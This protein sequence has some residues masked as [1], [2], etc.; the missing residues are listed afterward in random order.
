MNPHALVAV[1]YAAGILGIVALDMIYRGLQPGRESISFFEMP[2]LIED[3]DMHRLADDG[4][5]IINKQLIQN[6]ENNDPERERWN[7]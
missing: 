5:K 7:G 4:V 1:V 2:P 3:A 6:I